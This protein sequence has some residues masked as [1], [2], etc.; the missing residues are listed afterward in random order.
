MLVLSRKPGQE[1]VIG[2]NIRL[3]VVAIRGRQ[4]QLGITAPL[5]VP[6]RRQEL[7]P[8]WPHLAANKVIDEASS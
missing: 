4:V 5:E 7:C 6:I 8:S 1:L 3:T 2:D